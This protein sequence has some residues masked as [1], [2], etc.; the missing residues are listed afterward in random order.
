MF[1]FTFSK[2]IESSPT[3]EVDSVPFRLH[4]SKNFITLEY[5]GKSYKESIFHI[6]LILNER[7]LDFNF[8][9]CIF[10]SS[11]SI[12]L[13]DI[14]SSKLNV[15]TE[16]VQDS[17]H[18]LPFV[19]LENLGANC[20]I[21]SLLQTIYFLPYLK[22]ELY[23][24]NGY[25]CYLMQRLFYSLDNA[26]FKLSESSLFQNITDSLS[27]VPDL[28]ITIP[29]LKDRLYNLIKNLDFVNHINEHQDVHEFSKVLFDVLENENKVLTQGL[30][31]GKIASIV[32]CEHGCVSK[33]KQVFQDLQMVIKDVFQ[34]KSNRTIY[35]SLQ[36]FCSYS[37][38][39][40]FQCEK[41]GK[42]KAT[43]KVLFD[44]LPPALFI[45]LNRFSMDWE[46]EKYLKINDYY[47]FP[48]ELDLS[49]YMD[50]DSTTL[51]ENING[52][53][54]KLYSVIV[55]SGGVDEGHFFCYLNINGKYYKFNDESVYECSKY[56]AVDWNF[57]G[58][59]PNKAERKKNFSAYYLVYCRADSKIC[60]S[61]DISDKAN[62]K[63]L[64][65]L[66]Q[67]VEPCKIT[68]SVPE[69]IIGYNGPGNFNISDYCYPQV[70][71]KSMSCHETDNLAKIFPNK[72]IFDENFNLFKNKILTPGPFYL[73]SSKRQGLLVFVKIF[74][75]QIWCTYPNC[76]YSLG[77]KNVSSMSD[78]DKFSNLD[79]YDLFIE[80]YNFESR[81]HQVCHLN[82]FD[83]IKEGDSVVIA[84]K[85]SLFEEFIERFY[86]YQIL[87]VFLES[88]NIPI[89][90][91]RSLSS[92][93]LK[94][95]IF[96][97]FH[98]N[99]IS[100]LPPDQ[101][102]IEILPQNKI[103]CVVNQGYYLYYFG[104]QNCTSTDINLIDHIHSFVLSSSTTVNE[105]IKIFRHSDFQCMFQLQNEEDLC[106]I[107]THRSSTNLKILSG[108]ST[109]DPRMGFLV[110]H[111]CLKSPIKISFYKGMYELINYPFFIENP[112]IILDLRSKYFFSNRIVK[113]NGSSYV[114]CLPNDLISLEPD[115]ILLIEKE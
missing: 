76:L 103:N 75:P 42:V 115:E 3:I 100:F 31:E 106:V 95:E 72:K 93:E 5:L 18:I 70:K 114:E 40:G 51:K 23:K 25:H 48:E 64:L 20:Y 113:F 71:S 99:Q 105:V 110:I 57:G 73:T 30:I 65:K 60:P 43:K 83:K 9:Y 17:N 90:V 21:N 91:P 4:R 52:C 11:F 66:S 2:F 92:D 111:R 28:D 35:E 24:S 87:N 108:S 98:N 27:N 109:L 50:H 63:L 1:S 41:H 61:F 101:E 104:I 7:L 29:I 58:V 33:T 112:G 54:Y 107:E 74:T 78:F 81:E 32:E 89:F 102:T 36:E 79:K 6:N 88:F 59:Y 84:P 34:N 55:H 39:E 69:D 8:C 19:G 82:S 85:E 67:P 22:E 45:L 14:H 37:E 12:P 80:N 77:E 53:K 94:H 62:E 26:N 46:S 49:K 56:E 96:R 47:E 13:E 16:I 10:N 15:D 68:Y 86:S 44:E 97:N 38:V